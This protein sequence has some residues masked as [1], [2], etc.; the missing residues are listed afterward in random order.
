MRSMAAES[1]EVASD[2]RGKLLAAML[3]ATVI[4]L[5]LVSSGSLGGSAAHAAV[6]TVGFDLLPGQTPANTA[7]SL[8]SIESC[9]VVNREQ[10]FSVD[11]FFDGIPAGRELVGLNYKI[12]FD[13]DVLS[14]VAQDHNYLLASAPGSTVSSLGEGVPDTTTPHEVGLLDSG[15][16]EVGPQKG[17]L[18]RYTFEVDNLAPGGTFTLSLTDV[19]LTDDVGALPV[20]QLWVADIVLGDSC[21]PDDDDGDGDPDT[22]D[23]CPAAYNPSQ[24]DVNTN[25]LGDACDPDADSDGHPKE[26]EEAYGGDDVD[27][28]V[29]PELCDGVDNNGNTQID[30]GA[31]NDGNSNGT[32]D[33]RDSALNCDGDGTPNS[34]EADDDGDAFSD[35]SEAWTVTD[36]CDPCAATEFANDETYDALAPDFNDDQFVDITDVSIMGP[37]AFNIIAGRGDNPSYK[38]RFDLNGDWFVDITDVS[39]MGPPIFNILL[40]CT[41]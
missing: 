33:C 17:V 19:T 5:A 10:Q 25:G 29:S 36:P 18:G 4:A 1:A 32:A 30:E 37:P 8:G 21:A 41:P 31:W 6:T 27:F 26:E 2:M 14:V 34:G 39:L 13:Q 3:A 35:V 24:S 15:T 11:V 28:D 38:A 22:S 7:T 20:D 12:N 16:E 9:I 23:N 40:S